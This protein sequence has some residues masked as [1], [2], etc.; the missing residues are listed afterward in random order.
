MSRCLVLLLVCLSFCFGLPVEAAQP[1]PLIDLLPKDSNRPALLQTLRTRLDD[2]FQLIPMDAELKD[3]LRWAMPDPS[4]S[5]CPEQKASLVVLFQEQA[6]L[7]PPDATDDP[8]VPLM[9]LAEEQAN[10]LMLD[11]GLATL[12]SARRWVPCLSRVVTRDE[13]FRLHS[14]EAVIHVFKGDGLGRKSFL[15]ALAVDPEHRLDAGTPTD[16]RDEYLKAT[17]VLKDL[18]FLTFDVP[19]SPASWRVDG[20]EIAELDDLRPGRHVI[21]RLGPQGAIR[22]ALVEIPASKQGVDVSQ[23]APLG[24]NTDEE[25]RA[26]L[27]SALVTGQLGLEQSV[28]LNA[29]R[30]A[31]RIERLAFV[32]MPESNGDDA[33]IYYPP[34]RKQGLPASR[35][36]LQA[37][38]AVGMLHTLGIGE[39]RV[40]YS[41]A[42]G[43]AL[44]IQ[45]PLTASRTEWVDGVSEPLLA[46]VRGLALEFGVG[47]FPHTL[48]GLPEDPRC[49]GYSGGTPTEAELAG[50]A[51]CIESGWTLAGQLG[52]GYILPAGPLTV[53]PKVLLEGRY[54]PVLIHPND[55]GDHMAYD[56]GAGGIVAALRVGYALPARALSAQVVAELSGGIDVAIREAQLAVTVPLTATVGVS[57]AF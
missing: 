20:R 42:V 54:L 55:D 37:A 44:T 27:A 10:A 12:E 24:L 41:P 51:A 21:Q 49:G 5:T 1:V 40:V 8:F 53:T 4:K 47:I 32:V 50:A 6:L 57:T 29:Y 16:V 30:N 48:E 52:V 45:L 34:K 9:N 23:L 39:T 2:S 56:A 13:V 43:Y 19:E 11:A 17:K 35:V 14:L 22:S 18:P 28:S 46:P 33:V 38:L 25:V 15:E 3:S 26:A 31:H 36:P 7:Q